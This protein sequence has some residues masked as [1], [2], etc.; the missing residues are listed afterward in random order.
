MDTKTAS[1]QVTLYTDEQTRRLYATDASS[2]QELPEAVAY[3]KNTQDIIDLI[4][5]AR[6]NNTPVTAR[7][8]GTSLAGQTTGNG[9]IMDIGRKMNRIVNIDARKQT[10]HVQPGVIRDTLNREAAAHSLL[11]GPD[12]ATTSRCMIGGMIGNNSCGLFSIKHKT[13]REHVLEIDAVLSDGSRATFKPLSEEELQQKMEL[14]SLEGDIYRQMVSLIRDHKEKILANY[15]HPEVIRRNT[16]YALDRL[17]EMEPF[18]EGGRP[19]NL[20]ELLCGSEGTLAVTASAKLNLVQRDPHSILLT[21]QFSSIRAAMEATVEAVKMDPA[22]VEL[23]DDII[24]DAT[25]NNIEQKKNRFF[26]E[27]E[28]K[29]VLIIQFDGDDPNQLRA[30]AQELGDRLKT[31]GL[32]SSS[33]VITDPEKIDRVWELRK[34]GLGLLM[35]LGAE[36]RTPTFCEDTAVRVPDL[37][38]YVD[39]F[40][41]ILDKHD[42]KCVFYAHA[43]VG[44]LHLRPVINLKKEKEIEKMK[45]MAGEIADL[46]RKYRGS[47]SGEHGDGRTRAPYIEKVLGSEMMPLLKQVKQIWDP[48][49]LLNPG[50]IVDPKP[51]EADLRYSPSYRP[52][53]VNTTFNWRREEGFADAVELCNGAGVCRKLADSGGTMCPS[54]MATKREKDSTRGRANLFRQLFSGRQAEAFQSEE[55]RDALDLC[56]SCKACKS[57]CPANVDMARM[58]AEFMQGWHEENGIS[59][60]ERF[61]G[62]AGTL[63]P[64]ASLFPKLSNWMLKQPVVKELLQQWIGIDKRRDL[65][66]FATET[67]MDWFSNRS[68]TNRPTSNAEAGRS[69]V[70][71]IDIF[72]NYHDPD[73]GKAAVQFLEATGHRVIVPEI[74][75]LGRP[76]LSKGMVD[77]AKQVLDQSLPVL[78]NYAEQGYP[79]IGLEPSELLTLRDEYLD[80]CD[81]DQL[82]AAQQVAEQSVTFEEFVASTLQTNSP[83]GTSN[84]VYIHGHCHAKALIGNTAV[85]DALQAAGYE[86][87]IL[88]TG[89]CGM[90]GSFGYE[91]NHYEVSMDIGE[92][93]LFPALRKLPDD[94]LICAPGFSCR[95][96][97]N[98]GVDRKAV[99]PAELVAKSLT[100]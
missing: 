53:E 26:L 71:L 8:A 34:A 83:P 100:T 40:Q 4:Q 50:K 86:T 11:F 84:K 79:I 49:N 69:V 57:E 99:H 10:A 16:G 18:T 54:Y 77:H 42:S 92:L 30:K 31:L 70:L 9:I 37:P 72:T 6:A 62:Q 88:Q 27:G 97:I 28:P 63:Y 20:A 96:Q 33:P 64:L 35:G 3:P 29:A 60:H 93:T 44:E 91:E 13:T 73:I 75:E 78:T 59:L 87:E 55:L 94:A 7:G 25:K 39:D 46:V 89:C 90:A 14:D 67:F 98:D 22:A 36:G 43:S 5:Y 95:H 56:L 66:A 58:K 52:P 45:V 19:F 23:I 85:E 81:D 2:Y 1:E 74:H 80:L 21:P 68:N 47:L 17:C 12:T 61:F 32:S 41:R 38:D 48:Q 51:M 76:Q 65:P 15:P 24:L 82:P